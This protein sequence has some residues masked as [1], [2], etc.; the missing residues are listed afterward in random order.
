[1]RPVIIASFRPQ[2]DRVALRCGSSVP[3]IESVIHTSRGEREIL[4][5]N[6]PGLYGVT[7]EAP[8]QP[9]ATIETSGKEGVSPRSSLK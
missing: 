6:L 5:A 9:T 3:A 2:T 4:D 7:I 8:N 1:M